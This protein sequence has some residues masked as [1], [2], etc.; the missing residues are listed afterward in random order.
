MIV[1]VFEV[2]MKE[3][4]GARYFELAAALR[5]EVE[6]I[7]GFISVERFESLTTPGKYLS[8]QFWRDLAAVDKWREH[9]AHAVAQ[10]LGKSEIFADFRITVAQAVRS[11]EM[12]ER[13][14]ESA[15]PR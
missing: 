11:Y 6:K 13:V 5:S 1:V 7:D 10:R 12:A 9:A 15:A 4:Q 2:T 8:L 3:G 14:G